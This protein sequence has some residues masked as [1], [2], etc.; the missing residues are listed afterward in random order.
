MG[1]RKN[2]DCCQRNSKDLMKCCIACGVQLLVTASSGWNPV[3]S[4]QGAAIIPYVIPC[5][6]KGQNI[7]EYDTMFGTIDDFP[8]IARGNGEIIPT[9]R[10]EWQ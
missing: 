7:F 6:K 10:S 8:F 1:G 3:L 4:Y 5:T 2:E 9:Y